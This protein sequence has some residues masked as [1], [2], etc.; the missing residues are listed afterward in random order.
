MNS[1]IQILNKR[2]KNDMSFIHVH[3]PYSFFKRAEW[4]YMRSEHWRHT[5]PRPLVS[6]LS[7]STLHLAT[8]RPPLAVCI[9]FAS[10]T[11]LS[12]TCPGWQL[13]GLTPCPVTCYKN[14]NI[15]TNTVLV[16]L[17]AW[18]IDKWATS[19]LLSKISSLYRIACQRYWILYF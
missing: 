18:L 4:V 1:F 2:R 17:K 7:L 8:L 5:S 11:Q 12:L 6:S 10:S 13:P 14:V 19:R 16:W 9:K 3:F 15:K